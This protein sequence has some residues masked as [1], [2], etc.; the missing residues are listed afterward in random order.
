MTSLQSSYAQR[1]H[2][3]KPSYWTAVASGTGFT[4]AQL[5]S[6]L[7]AT[8]A[9]TILLRTPTVLSVADASAFLATVAT[10]AFS[11][12]TNFRDMGRVLSLQS[13]GHEV[14]RFAV[15]QPVNGV[16]TEGV[17]DAYATA[18]LYV[19]VGSN[20]PYAKTVQVALSG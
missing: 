2:A 9:P 20:D 12:R 14:F 18:N 16:T 4:E 13:R 7:Q 15:L 17:P 11:V 19:C 1:G 6:A 10:T 5:R 8:A 3:R